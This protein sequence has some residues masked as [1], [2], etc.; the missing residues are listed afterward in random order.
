MALFIDSD[1]AVRLSVL[2]LDTVSY[3]QWTVE[4][5]EGFVVQKVFCLTETLLDS[6]Y[7]TCFTWDFIYNYTKKS[8]FRNS[9]YVDTIDVSG[10]ESQQ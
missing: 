1:W 7:Q 4:G 10:L 5:V 8:A 2:N 6:L 3:N 9:F